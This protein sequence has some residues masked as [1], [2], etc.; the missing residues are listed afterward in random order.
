[1]EL[2]YGTELFMLRLHDHSTIQLNKL[3]LI[4]CLFYSLVLLGGTEGA[5][6]IQNIGQ[7]SWL[8]GSL[9]GEKEK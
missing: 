2:L 7:D 6:Q 8:T 5:L 3:L 9:E 1:M 4:I